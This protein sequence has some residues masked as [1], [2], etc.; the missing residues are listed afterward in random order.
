MICKCQIPAN[1][2]N[3]QLDGIGKSKLVVKNDATPWANIAM[4]NNSVGTNRLSIAKFRLT[5]INT[6]NSS[7][8]FVNFFC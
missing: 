1:S 6:I 7:G 8:L 2:N 5:T 3:V 4:F